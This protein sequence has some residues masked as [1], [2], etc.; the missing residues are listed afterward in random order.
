M[1]AHKAEA[2]STLDPWDDSQ[3]YPELWP[4]YRR[5]RQS[6]PYFDSRHGGYWVLSR[7][8][9]VRNAAA[10]TRTFSSA[11]G[12]VLGVGTA[13]RRPFVPVEMDPPEHGPY[14]ALL[15]PLMT[16]I[17]LERLRPVLVPEIE[18]RISRMAEAGTADVVRE[19][20]EPL[21]VVAISA[22]MG[23]DQEEAL[24]M[25]ALAVAIA[26]AGRD[27]SA[28]ALADFQAFLLE[29]ISDRRRHPREDHLTRIARAK[30]A[31]A[32]IPDDLLVTLIQGLILAGHHTT[33]TGL[34]FLLLR[35]AELGLLPQLKADPGL[36]MGTVHET[37]R[38]DP[39][40]HLQGRTV[41]RDLTIRG[42]ALTAGDY[43]VLLFA[44]AHRDE[45]EFA[46]PD[47]FDIRRPVH[48]LAF[49]HGVHRCVGM[50]LA[51]LEMRLVLEAL[52]RN[53]VSCD[54]AAEPDLVAML[55]GHH[56]GVTRLPV[57]V[58]PR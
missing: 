58:R 53:W 36:C 42:S 15:Q 19:L 18:R 51:L 9:E 23:L 14:R 8:A 56:V 46:D 57:S 50:P 35:V 55:F 41:T 13:G 44:S 24:R 10:D 39:P 1:H 54:L 38:Y 6:A 52:T 5:L 30:V 37:L 16:R 4:L 20:A 3:P 17:E 27:E 43:V 34:S 49:G 25:R 48:H 31:D 21:P 47:R 22:L 26:E 40:I 33:I 11:G 2:G 45:R 28:R 29:L 32:P 7:Y 12:V